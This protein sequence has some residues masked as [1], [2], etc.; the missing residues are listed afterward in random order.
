MY[1]GGGGP[2]GVLILTDDAH[3]RVDKRAYGSI[4]QAAATLRMSHR[5]GYE[6][7][8]ADGKRQ[9]PDYYQTGVRVKLRSAGII[10]C[11]ENA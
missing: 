4:N 2:K 3:R 10:E 5:R 7:L 6:L 8:S 11:V 1:G 9:Q